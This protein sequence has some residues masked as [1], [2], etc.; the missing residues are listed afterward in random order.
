MLRYQDLG[1]SHSHHKLYWLHHHYGF[2]G[3]RVCE[4]RRSRI[5]V[6]YHAHNRIIPPITTVCSILITFSSC[7]PDRIKWIASVLAGHISQAHISWFSW[8]MSTYRNM[9]LSQHSCVRHHAVLSAALKC[10]LGA[11][12]PPISPAPPLIH[13][14]TWHSDFPLRIRLSFI[15]FMLLH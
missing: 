3:A 10:C 13:S 4:H 1:S 5:N 9:T 14:R 2:R 6:N 8:F 15:L 11:N 12:Y 7:G